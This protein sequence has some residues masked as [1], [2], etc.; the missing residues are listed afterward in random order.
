MDN[1]KKIITPINIFRLLAAAN[2]IVISLYSISK[3]DIMPELTKDRLN[4]LTQLL[5]MLLFL[6][7]GVEGVKDEDKTKRYVSYFN[8]GVAI[9]MLIVNVFI[10]LK[11]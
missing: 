4:S 2:V 9:I 6:I 3:G 11:I 5:L 10:F 7:S 1:I 8:F